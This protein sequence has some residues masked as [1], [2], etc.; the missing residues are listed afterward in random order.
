MNLDALKDFAKQHSISEA[1]SK[2]LFIQAVNLAA[3]EKYPEYDSISFNIEKQTL[4]F[5]TSNVVTERPIKEMGVR[6]VYV[7]FKY[8]FDYLL[9]ETYPDKFRF[10]GDP[11]EKIRQFYK[12]QNEVAQKLHEDD[13]Y[14]YGPY[15]S[16]CQQAPCMC[17][18]RESTS[19]VHDF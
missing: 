2:L 17:S 4:F 3:M 5:V 11:S 13:D 16:A 9:S 14:E 1:T 18:D 8:Y 12:K 6:F 19:T 7:Y 10:E 15:C